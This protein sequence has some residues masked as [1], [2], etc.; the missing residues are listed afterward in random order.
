MRVEF[1]ENVR[2]LLS[3]GAKQL[4]RIIPFTA[5]VFDRVL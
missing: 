3:L 1:R 5:R 2:A 4:V